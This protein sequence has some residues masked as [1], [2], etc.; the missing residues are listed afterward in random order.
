MGFQSMRLP[1]WL[2]EGWAEYTGWRYQGSEDPPFAVRRGISAAARSHRLPSLRE[3]DRGAPINSTNPGV[4]YGVSALA[5]RLLLKRG[6]VENLWA[7]VVN[8]SW[9]FAIAVEPL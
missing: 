4:A 6:G 9:P 1:L 3:M 5:V 2:N 8:R 7:L